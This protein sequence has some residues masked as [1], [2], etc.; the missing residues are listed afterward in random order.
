VAYTRRGWLTVVRLAGLGM[1]TPSLAGKAGASAFARLWAT[2]TGAAPCPFR[3]AVI[4]DEITQDFEKA[5]QIVS[6]EFG[7]GWIE[8]RSMWD[9]N[10]TELDAKQI[11]DA[12]K[13]LEEHKLRVTDIASPLFKTDWPGAPRSSQSQTRDQF[14]ADFDA[15]AQ[16]KLL[17][18]CIS[19][20]K[21]F[22]TDRIRCF[23]FWRL[24]DPKPY[25]G[26]INAKRHQ[27][28]ERCAKENISL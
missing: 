19:L 12:K 2:E 24:D 4:N 7:L 6:G 16:D 11:A 9:K 22:N 1:L 8:L 23:D 18:H 26:A 5:C 28:A 20:C 13:I 17:E 25:R 15:N 10:V 21:S 27:A 14:H 3:L